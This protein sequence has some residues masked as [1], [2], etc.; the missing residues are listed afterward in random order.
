MLG[1]VLHHER[2][3]LRFGHFVEAVEV[4]DEA[5]FVEP[6]ADAAGLVRLGGLSVGLARAVGE[7]GHGVDLVSFAT[8]VPSLTLEATST[9]LRLLNDRKYRWGGTLRIWRRWVRREG[10]RG[11]R[12]ERRVGMYLDTRCET[13]ARNVTKSTLRR[14]GSSR[15]ATFKKVSKQ[16]GGGGKGDDVSAACRRALQGRIGREVWVGDR[17]PVTTRVCSPTTRTRGLRHSRA[18]LVHR[19]PP[20]SVLSAFGKSTSLEKPI[21]AKSV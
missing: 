20:G 18:S 9:P 3:K 17:A 7:G 13:R 12:R 14:D 1:V 4:L 2:R 16:S 19:L 5:G 10:Y 8:L 15:L 21:F 11:W 6:L